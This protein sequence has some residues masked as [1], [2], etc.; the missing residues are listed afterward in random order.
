MEGKN[1][2]FLLKGVFEEIKEPKPF[3]SISGC[4]HIWLATDSIS[5]E[6]YI[7]TGN[8]PH[9]KTAWVSG[10]GK[11]MIQLALTQQCFSAKYRSL[12]AF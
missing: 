7:K 10:M 11:K 6:Q 2:N 4:L 12:D 8:A 9:K 5:T 3:K 1:C